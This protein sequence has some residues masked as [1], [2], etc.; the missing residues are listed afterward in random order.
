MRRPEPRTTPDPLAS[1]DDFLKN[2][3]SIM[4]THWPQSQVVPDLVEPPIRRGYDRQPDC[5]QRLTD[6]G[7]LGCANSITNRPNHPTPRQNNAVN[8]VHNP[9]QCSPIPVNRTTNPLSQLQFKI[10]RAPPSYNTSSSP[11]TSSVQASDSIELL[12]RAPVKQDLD[13]IMHDVV[14]SSKMIE[15]SKKPQRV[16]LPRDQF[17]LPLRK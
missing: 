15:L 16:P 13:A 1:S 14:P 17:V 2:F 8:C 11:S 4:M 9:P 7:P 6:T 3:A 5:R 10:R 12:G